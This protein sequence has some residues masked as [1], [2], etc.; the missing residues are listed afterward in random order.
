MTTV[1]VLRIWR[2]CAWEV[3]CTVA[4]ILAMEVL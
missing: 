4:L 1:E 2:H 3:M